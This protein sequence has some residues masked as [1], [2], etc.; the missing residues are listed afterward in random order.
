MAS[1][2][3]RL[4]PSHGERLRGL[5]D[6][7]QMMR[8]RGALARRKVWPCRR[9]SRGRRASS[10]PRR[11]RHPDGLREGEREVGLA[12]GRRTD[13]RE[14]RPSRHGGRPQ[15][16][17][18]SGDGTSSPVRWCADAAVIR[19]CT[20]VP[21]SSASGRCTI[22]FVRVRAWVDGPRF[23]APSTRTSN[24]P[25]HLRE[26]A[27]ERDPLLQLDQ[28][29]EALLHD[30]LGD[31]V[32]ERGGARARPRRVLE[33]VRAVEP[34]P[35]D[36]VERVGEV[37]LGLAGEPH[38][39]VGR[40]RDVGDGRADR[41]EPAQVAIAPVRAP[42][43][44]EH[45]IRARLQREVDVLADG[46]RLRHGLDHVGREVVR[47]RRREPHPSDALD[48]PDLPEEFG[49]QR[50]VRRARNRDVA[51]VR[52]H[53]LPEQ[54]DLDD[55]AP[56]EPLHLRQ[57]VADRARPL[58]APDERHDAERAGVVASRRD[59]HPGSEVVVTRG[60]QRAGEDLGVLADVH[61]RSVVV[62]GLQ[63]LEEMRQRVRADH[64]VHPRRA[65][66]D[67]A[68]V[69]LRQAARPRRSGAPGPCPSAASGAR[70]CRRAGCP[71]SHGWRTC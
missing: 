4:E 58:R 23:P 61:L 14:G 41:L 52:V 33:R 53:V 43:R 24:V 10:R 11:S 26:R 21:G 32:V 60:R 5:G 31:L 66:L 59:R 56:G 17:T 22:R 30:L 35:L 9:P 69:L 51:T 67:L 7:D 65:P 55:P 13:E 12:H 48:L 46:R 3:A 63:Q 62:R 39:D 25:P 27:F 2:A 28:P 49:E 16:A 70:G 44:L 45:A 15:T 71:R 57:D 1:R 68:S 29:V 18:A 20:N 37:L 64:D 40:H 47:M 19:A 6:V 50:P 36:H 38:D 34:R 54:G 8:D 42:H